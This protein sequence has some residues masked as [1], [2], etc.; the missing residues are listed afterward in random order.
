MLDLLTGKRCTVFTT[1]PLTTINP[2]TP[3]RLASIFDRNLKLK[4]KG[5][6]VKALQQYL[7]TTLNLPK[8]LIIDGIFGKY[9]LNALKIFQKDNNLIPD[10]IFGPKTKEVMNKILAAK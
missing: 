1:P 8:P 6:D 2:N 4:M 9:T 5:S 10:G 3:D 7:N